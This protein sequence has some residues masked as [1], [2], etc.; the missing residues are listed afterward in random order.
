VAGHHGQDPGPLRGARENTRPR[1]H[2]PRGG[3]GPRQDR[4]NRPRPA[5]SLGPPPPRDGRRERRPQG[6]LLRP[7]HRGPRRRR[8][9]PV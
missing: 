1:G 4:A 5:G 6:G 9:G 8:A 7:L 3:R 2:P